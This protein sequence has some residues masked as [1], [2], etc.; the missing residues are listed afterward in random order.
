MAGGFGRRLGDLTKTTPKPMLPL[1]GKPICEH[2]V[3][4]LVDNNISDLFFSV[5][6]L[7]D[8]IKDYFGNGAAHGANISYLEETR[9]LGTAGCLSLLPELAKPLLVVNGDVVTNVQLGRLVE[10]HV[11]ADLDVTMSVKQHAVQIPYG[12]VD[13]V[14]GEVVLIREKPKIPMMINVAIYVLSPRVLRHIPANCQMDMPALVQAIIPHGY[15][16]GIFPLVEYW[17]DVG[18]VPELER[19][20]NKL[21]VNE[22]RRPLGNLQTGFPVFQ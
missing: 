8:T 6:H 18:T 19:A 5:Y 17:I 12:V 11:A 9:P 21:A 3:E 14:D 16:V 13:H 1:A 7:K 22:G 15:K 4:N 20:R 2:L 10:Y